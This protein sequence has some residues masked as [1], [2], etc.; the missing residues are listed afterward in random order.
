MHAKEEKT[1]VDG[2]VTMRS[3]REPNVDQRG[4]VVQSTPAMAPKMTGHRHCSS[5]SP[6]RAAEGV[7]ACSYVPVRKDPHVMTAARGA[8]QEKLLPAGAAGTGR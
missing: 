2:R 1:T 5:S 6:P 3:W 8:T 4:A 7:G